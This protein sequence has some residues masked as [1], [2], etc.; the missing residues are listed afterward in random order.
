MKMYHSLHTV[1]IKNGKLCTAL[2][3][4]NRRLTPVEKEF[5]EKYADKKGLE[6]TA[7]TRLTEA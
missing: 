7:Y 3:H 2:G 4:S 5:L 1:E 6:Y